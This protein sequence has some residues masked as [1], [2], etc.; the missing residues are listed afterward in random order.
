VVVDGHSARWLAQGFSWV[1]PK[2][3]AERP[4]GCRPGD[5]VELAD[6]SGRPLGTGI[7]DEGWIAVRRYR[8]DRGALDAP[9][10]AS[11]LQRCLARRRG[12][13]PP[14]TTAWRLAHAENDD[15]PG[16]RVDVWG[17]QLHLTLDSVAL[18]R[19][20]PALQQGLEQLMQP[21]WISL[22]F[23]RDPR[24][25]GGELPLAEWLLHPQGSGPAPRPEE[26]ETIVQERGLRYRVRPGAGSDAGLFAD[27]R[28]NRGWLEPHWSGRRVLNL[29]AFTGA[30]SLCAAKAGARQVVTS[31]LAATALE[32]ARENF[33]LNDLDP[34]DWEFPRQD[35]FKLLDRLRRT[36]RR[37][38]LVLA[39]PPPFSQAGG[40]TFSAGKDLARLAGACLRV[41]D[42]GGLLV[43]ACNQGSVSPRAF[44]QAVLQAGQRADRRLYQVHAGSQA[45][46]FPAAAHFPEGRYLKLGAWIA[47]GSGP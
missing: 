18:R 4:S 30:F 15:L 10:I 40:S 41:L 34:E 47:E 1:Y 44:H 45:P 28:D 43:L 14:E 33:R 2:E 24:D 12:L 26:R 5:Q 29:F 23:R 20:L 27:M 21:G 38:D 37:F 42:E 36:G 16:V 9:F 31:D 3:V 46:D 35:A 32:R 8:S 11:L 19:L 17:D 13:L 22:G 39:D 6:R 25:H 7:W